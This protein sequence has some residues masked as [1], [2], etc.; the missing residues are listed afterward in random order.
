[1][2]ISFI[3]S[4]VGSSSPTTDTALTLPGSM[5]AND[6]ILVVAVVGDVTVDN[7][8]DAP[9]EGGYTDVLGAGDLW[10]NFGGNNNANLD[11]FYKFHNGTDTTCTFADVGGANASNAGVMMVFRGVKLVADGG[12]FD[13]TPNTAT[14]TASSDAN[15]PSHN[16]SGGSGVWT[17]A[18]GATGHTGGA[19]ATF[20]FPTGYTTDAAQRA[21]NDTTDALVGMGYNTAPSD[22]EDPGAFTAATIGTAANNGWCAVTLSLSP[23][24]DAKAPPF[25]RQR[26][27][28]PQLDMD[29]WAA[30]HGFQL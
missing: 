11:L 22:P 16:W 17:V 3:G 25:Y 26:L 13:T 30:S 15:P 8:L 6:L 27:I 1:V 7:G 29:P 10:S 24:A 19:S 18:I 21:H 2:A 9:T 12:P 4:A 14:G 5:A 20:T 28:T 23:A